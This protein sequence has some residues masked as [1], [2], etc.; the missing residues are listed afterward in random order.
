MEQSKVL[1]ALS[2]LSHEA[3]LELV[4]LLIDA[5]DEG[6]PAGTIGQKLGL[7][8]SRLSFHLSALE[9][10]GL[11]RSRRASR[12]VIYSVDRDGM[13]STIGFLL[14]DCCREHPEVVACCHKRA[15]SDPPDEG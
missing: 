15:Q 11:I 7:G 5:G 4:R 9:Q 3:R 14:H 13:G 6:L 2:A 10:A 12:N 8:A 1:A